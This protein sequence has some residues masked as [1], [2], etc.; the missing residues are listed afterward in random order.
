MSAT[1]EGWR[2]VAIRECGEPLAELAPSE[3]I[4]IRSAYF[5]EGYASALPGIWLRESVAARLEQ[6]AHQLPVGMTLVLWDG[7]R[8]VELQAEL[9]ERYRAAIARESGLQ[10]EPL[11]IETQRFVSLPSTDPS[12][13]SPHLTGG[14]ID[15][16]LGTPDGI[17][18]DM[19]GE[20]DELGER[21]LPHYYEQAETGIELTYRNRRRLLR[22]AMNEAGFANYNEEWWHFD[23][24]NQ[25]WGRIREQ[26][27][28]YGPVF[29][30]ASTR[31]AA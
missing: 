27:A 16:T 26:E 21:S 13:P 17:P 25:F 29:L 20:F 19:G 30:D 18:L 2:S 28:I 3:R 12:R 8:P 31:R 14:S 15:L 9:Y 1:V 4:R 7:W 5:S 22:A 6:A 10:G 23:F 24:G 11:E